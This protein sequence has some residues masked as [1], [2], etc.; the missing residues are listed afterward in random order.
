MYGITT[1]V[2]I[3]LARYGDSTKKVALLNGSLSKRREFVESAN[4]HFEVDEIMS[5]DG[6]STRDFQGIQ[7]L[8]DECMDR[9]QR[10]GWCHVSSN[11]CINIREFQ[12]N[13]TSTL[14]MVSANLSLRT[15]KLKCINFV[16]STQFV[17]ALL[18]GPNL[19]YLSLSATSCTDEGASLI[20]KALPKC[21]SLQTLCLG[22]NDIENEGARL[23][24]SAVSETP[25]LRKLDISYNS[26]RDEG[27][28]TFTEILET[29]GE[30]CHLQELDLDG[31]FHSS[32]CAIPLRLAATKC[33]GLEL[34]CDSAC[35]D[36]YW[37]DF[38]LLS[39]GVS[40]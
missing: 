22:C 1:C 32:D 13:D 16:Y 25:S 27:V 14:S 20:A 15:L 37:D 31:N 39:F 29:L 23:I 24:A 10:E 21:L 36:T 6:S 35:N 30:S 11:F 2:V 5:R 19:R 9:A 4:L 18:S 12:A 17:E 40:E 33:H 28:V 3:A 8:F 7:K 34:R 38:G 26:I